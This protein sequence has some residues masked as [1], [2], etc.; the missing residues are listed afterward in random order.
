MLAMTF[1]AA[2]SGPAGI[3]GLIAGAADQPASEFE[4]LDVQTMEP[5]DTPSAFSPQFE[6]ASAV[7]QPVLDVGQFQANVSPD[8]L[9]DGG[10]AGLLADDVKGAAHGADR[11]LGNSANFYGVEADGDDFVFV[12]DMSGS[13]SGSRFRRAKNE[14]RRSI[15]ALS[16]TQR[17]FVIFFSDNAWPMPGRE[18]IEATPENLSDTRHWLQQAACQGGTNPLPALLDAIDL[19]PDA[20]FLLSD[21]R[22]DPNTAFQVK[23]AETV[24]AIPIHTIG[25]ANAAGEPMLRA[26]SDATGGTYRFVR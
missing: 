11:P 26:I 8:V 20:I 12:V 18:L 15:E 6:A 5:A 4:K 22:F 25:F 1:T 14:V 21:G 2:E 10:L 13:M 9:G 17:Y 7:S 16:P 24:P 19:D 3:S 23:D